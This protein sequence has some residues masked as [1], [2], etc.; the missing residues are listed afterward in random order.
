MRLTKSAEICAS[1]AWSGVSTTMLRTPAP[2]EEA[3][4]CAAGEILAWVVAHIPRRSS[5]KHSLQIADEKHPTLKGDEYGRE[6]EEQRAARTTTAQRL[7]DGL[8]LGSVLDRGGD[9][10]RHPDLPVDRRQRLGLRCRQ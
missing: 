7:D 9:A 6:P 2:H 10:R 3:G 8:G 4:H 1:S 5:D